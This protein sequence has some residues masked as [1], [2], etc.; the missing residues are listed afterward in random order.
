LLSKVKAEGPFIDEWREAY[1]TISK[2]V[3]E[4]DIASAISGAAL[5]V[6]D[7]RELVSSRHA[8]AR[9]CLNANPL[10]VQSARRLVRRVELFVTTSSTSWPTF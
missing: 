1:G 6:K 5:S 2:D 10:S 3:E 7:E 4:V 9:L 8:R